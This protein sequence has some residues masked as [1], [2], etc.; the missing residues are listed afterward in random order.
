M[1]IPAFLATNGLSYPSLTEEEYTSVQSMLIVI[2]SK[3]FQS[4]AAAG[5]MSL[6]NVFFKVSLESTHLSTPSETRSIGSFRESDGPGEEEKGVA[7]EGSS[8]YS[9]LAPHSNRIG[10]LQ[11]RTQQSS[12]YCLSFTSIHHRLC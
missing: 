1:D 10:T 7:E 12:R 5:R 8:D 4:A 11:R 6:A 2:H 3:I 9:P